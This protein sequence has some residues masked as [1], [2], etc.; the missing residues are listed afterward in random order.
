M[1]AVGLLP[2][3]APLW[4]LSAPMG[5]VGLGGPTVSPPATAALLD[6]IPHHPTPRGALM[7]DGTPTAPAGSWPTDVLDRF[8]SA[9]EIEISARRVDGSLRGYVP[10]WAVIVDG[11]L[12]VRSYRGGDG[13]WYRHATEHPF[14]AIRTGG[15]QLEVTFAPAGQNVRPAV[16]AAYRAKYARYG[17][18]YLRPMLA[19]PAVAA[20][21]RVCPQN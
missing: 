2:A 7:T 21:L 4:L 9:E 1:A 17:D 5:L 19:E 16:D 6:T 10:I 14:G 8:G 15:R 20:T 18:S 3:T 12:Y 13:V 11:A